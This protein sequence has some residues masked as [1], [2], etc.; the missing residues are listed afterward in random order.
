MFPSCYSDSRQRFL[1]LARQKNWRIETL[2]LEQTGPDGEELAI[3]VAFSPNEQADRRLVI[4]SGV[5]GVEGFFGA[6]VQFAT[7]EE[8]IDELPDN[9]GCQF[10]HAI[11]PYGYAHR[12][13]FN[14]ENVDPNRNFL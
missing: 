14:E 13:R 7:L 1:D 5:H 2:P 9:V 3:D 10:I 11:N 6:A 8:W 4:S 12:R